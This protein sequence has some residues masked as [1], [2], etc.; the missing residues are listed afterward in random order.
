MPH[1]EIRDV[2]LVYDTPAGRVPGVQAASFDIEQSEFLCLVGP[3]GCG[4]S[5]LLN[6]IAGFLAPTGGEIR[7]GGKQV[8]G[9]GH[10]PRHRVPGFRPAVSLAHRARQRRLRPGN[11]G[12]REG[13][14]RADRAQAIGAGE[15][16]KVRPIL[17]APPVGR[18]AAAGRHRPRAGLQSGR[19]AD[20]RAVRG[21][22]RAHP[23][24][25][26]AAAGRR[27]AGDAQDGDLCDPQRGRGGL[28]RRPG[29]RD[30]AASG[31][32]QD[33][34]PHRSAAAARSAQR[35]VSGVSETNPPPARRHGAEDEWRIERWRKSDD[36]L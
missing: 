2:S 28:S 3:S 30:D 19:A 26:A 13:G 11:E 23:R 10:G 9:H 18:H 17:S 25:H 21:A 16:G 29:D 24:R 20:G 7:I 14:A 8:T 31:H 1:I 33:G 6:I 34:D 15:A 12:R 4:K 5:T 35:R 27:L 32:G 22:R 36:D